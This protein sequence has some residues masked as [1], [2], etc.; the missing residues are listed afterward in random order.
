VHIQDGT[1]PE[2]KPFL[3]DLTDNGMSTTAADG[4]SVTPS[5]AGN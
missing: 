4:A 1:V 5:P 2:S 3:V